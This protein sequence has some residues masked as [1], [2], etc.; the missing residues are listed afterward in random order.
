MPYS[1]FGRFLLITLVPV[2]LVQLVAAY[3]FYER[4]WSSV[5]RHMAASLV[6]DVEMLAR[7]IDAV[8]EEER[9]KLVQIANSTLYLNVTFS[10]GKKLEKVH[11]PEL[12]KFEQLHESFS[13]IEDF[14]YSLF[15]TEDENV[16]IL[17]QTEQG[18]LRVISPIKRIS[19]PTTYIFI[20][21]MSGAA[22]LL[23]VVSIF[24]MRN[25]IRSIAKLADASERF[26]KGLD[27]ND[28]KPTGAME[29]RK[30]SQAF[31]DMKDRIQKQVSQRTE[32]LAGISHDLKTPI[33]RI[34]LQLA[35]MKQTQDIK[36]LQ[37][38][39][40]QMEH[41]VQEYLDFAKGHENTSTQEVNLATL[42][43]NICAGYRD[44]HHHIDVKVQTGVILMLNEQSVRRA[45]TNIM[46]NALRYAQNV[47]LECT[48]L[49]D[50]VRIIFDDDGPGIPPAKRA[51]AL[52]PFSR[53]EESR[54]ADK[55]G[56]GLGLAITQD[57]IT[58]HGGAVILD[59]SP[60]GGLRVIV[61]LPV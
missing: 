24:F 7:S 19:N 16:V 17:V 57:A 33:T 30:A 55:G 23:A 28:F 5:S 42:L 31:L 4:H 18:V 59:E 56:A 60:K 9:D 20:L 45:F 40:Q 43:R 54:N 3:A 10:E 61:T 8:S 48:Q 53:L 51:Q 22:L 46:D 15:F 47:Q 34:K 1:L 14:N 44:K 21:W 32:M 36:E 29:V 41:M 11:G 27:V 38:D 49:G 35:M 25:Q 26:G 52:K 12:E 6:G 39:L 2:V 50:S 58:R 37:N 13:G